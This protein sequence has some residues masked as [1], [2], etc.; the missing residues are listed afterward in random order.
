MYDVFFPFKPVRIGELSLF[1]VEYYV[2]GK[3]SGV[4]KHIIGGRGEGVGGGWEGSGG[5]WGGVGY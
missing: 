3:L 5:V 1:V 4:F 2:Y